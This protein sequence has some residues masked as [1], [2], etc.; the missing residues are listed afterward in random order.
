MARYC[1]Y[2]FK[3]GTKKDQLCND[4]CQSN[5]IF[6]KKHSTKSMFV[7]KE[8]KKELPKKE[9]P[10]TIIHINKLVNKKLQEDNIR[11]KILEL[12]TN[13]QN[14]SVIF[15]HYNNM[16]RTDSNSTEY[17]KNQLFGLLQDFY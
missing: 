17:Y 14:K 6:C 9:L 12:P 15:K 13:D 5:N 4:I 11:E 8:P 2:I 1:T 3:K 10:K 16:K 7:K